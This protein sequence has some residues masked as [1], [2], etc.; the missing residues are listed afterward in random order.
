MRT[1]VFAAVV[2]TIISSTWLL[3]KEDVVEK[4]S[5]QNLVIMYPIGDL[6][7][8]TKDGKFSPNLLIELL[9]ASIDVESFES[10]D[11]APF[12]ANASLVVTAN[13]DAHAK[14]QSLI[15]KLNTPEPVAK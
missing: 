11:I 13:Q 7:V 12:P 1:F 2:G 9:P 14:I 3:A 15:K 5:E 10:S 8:W 6:P 4:A